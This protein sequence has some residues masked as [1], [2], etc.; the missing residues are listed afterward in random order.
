MLLDAQFD[1]I[2]AREYLHLEGQSSC[3]HEYIAGRIYAMTGGSDRHNT[4]RS[5][6]I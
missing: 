5:P 1:R 3:R 2:T 6:S 4:I